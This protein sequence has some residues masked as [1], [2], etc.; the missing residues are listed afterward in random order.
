VTREALFPHLPRAEGL[1]RLG[2][3]MVEGAALT[4]MGKAMLSMAKLLGPEKTLLRSHAQY[5]A[6]TNFTEVKLSKVGERHYEFWMNSGAEIPQFGAGTL[7]AT[8]K[9]T[10]GRDVKVVA[11][12]IEPPAVTFDIQWT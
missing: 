12:K 1:F 4:L 6:G 2:E 3:S 7:A 10:G 11:A 9:Y 5:R 8:L